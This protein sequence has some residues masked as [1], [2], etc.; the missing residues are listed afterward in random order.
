MDFDH[1]LVRG[2]VLEFDNS[3]VLFG[4]ELDKC[5]L[6]KVSLLLYY[7]ILVL[8]LLDSGRAIVKQSYLLFS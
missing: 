7:I 5:L 2:Q 4:R 3:T 6:D 8:A 1:L